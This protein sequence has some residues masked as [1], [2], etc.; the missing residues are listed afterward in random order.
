MRKCLLMAILSLGCLKSSFAQTDATTTPKKDKVIDEYIGVQLNG[1]IRQVF[2][3]NNSTASP[4]V[5]PYLLTY[6]INLHKTGWGLRLGAGYNYTTTSSNDGITEASTKLNDFQFRFGIEKAFKL[7]DKWSTGVGV[8]GVYM[9]NN[10]NSSSTVHSFDTTTTA[11]KN[12]STSYGGGAMAWLRYNITEH[13]LIG[14]EASFYYTSGKETNT[15]DVTTNQNT[16]GGGFPI[17]T[18][19]ETVSKPTVSQGTFT[20]PISFYLIV[21]F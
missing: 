14:T 15:I 18:T 11:T 13:V 10:D 20:S 3:F 7:G 8:D 16:G 12:V 17:I 2:N 1:L 5:S 9:S 19:T 21:K 6:H 4:N